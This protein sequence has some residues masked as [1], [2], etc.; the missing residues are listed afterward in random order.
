MA[1]FPPLHEVNWGG[2]I[3]IMAYTSFQF[4]TGFT[5]TMCLFGLRCV[6]GDAN[7]EVAYRWS[8]FAVQAG[9]FIGSAVAFVLVIIMGVF[10]V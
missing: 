10:A 3:P 4:L 6:V 5:L 9:A 7:T 2:A 8:G 1:P